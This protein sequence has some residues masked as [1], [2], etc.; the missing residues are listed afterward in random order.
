MPPTRNE[1]PTD[2][3]WPPSGRDGV[4]RPRKSDV[5]MVPLG[6]VGN[7]K[8]SLQRTG[9]EQELSLVKPAG[10]GGGPEPSAR[11]VTH[12]EGGSDWGTADE[13]EDGIEVDR[14]DEVMVDP[15]LFRPV[16]GLSL[17]VARDGNQD[18]A[19]APVLS[20]EGGCQFV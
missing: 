4:P 5:A 3:C 18:R 19:L 10:R 12:T 11:P 16:S 2:A 17:P 6:Y 9:H 8:P 14:L 1:A 7:I 20:P 15:R 13:G